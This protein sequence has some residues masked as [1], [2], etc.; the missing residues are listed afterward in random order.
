[1][2]GQLSALLLQLGNCST[3][4]KIIKSLRPGKSVTI[5]TKNKP[6]KKH[7]FG[8]NRYFPFIISF[9]IRMH[10]IVIAEANSM[11]CFIPYGKYHFQF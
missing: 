2:P 5:F 10:L 8:G 4:S 9:L 1:M 7:I 6:L 3:L 11:L